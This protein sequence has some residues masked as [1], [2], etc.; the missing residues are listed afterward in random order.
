MPY[1]DS[2]CTIESREEV[3]PWQENTVLTRP[4]DKCQLNPNN[5]P[6]ILICIEPGVRMLV[7]QYDNRKCEGEPSAEFEMF[8]GCNDNSVGLYYYI[9]WEGSCAPDS[10]G[11]YKN[12]FVNARKYPKAK[13]ENTSSKVLNLY[14]MKI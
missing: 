1:L 3:V 11:K 8:W 4:L 7:Q 5:I 13:F 9:E 2:E 6:T 12:I 10:N 14:R